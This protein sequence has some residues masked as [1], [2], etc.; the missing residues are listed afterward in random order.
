MTTH[1]TLSAFGMAGPNLGPPPMPAA[2]RG[3]MQSSK[4][5]FDVDVD[6][7]CQPLLSAHISRIH[8]CVCVR[9]LVCLCVVEVSRK[10]GKSVS[11]KTTQWHLAQVL[12]KI[13]K[14]KCKCDYLLSALN[15]SA[16]PVFCLSS[17]VSLALPHS[18]SLSLFLSLTFSVSMLA[19]VS[20]FAL[21]YFSCLLWAK[22]REGET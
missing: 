9:V 12:A 3:A 18:V 19:V 22:G 20:V 1:K 11:Q 6:V 16:S 2:G 4:A 5:N 14:W 21:I 7:W 15:N 8:L 13:N 10:A 17:R